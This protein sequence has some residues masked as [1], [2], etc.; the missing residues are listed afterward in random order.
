MEASDGVELLS[1]LGWIGLLWVIS[2]FI[3]GVTKEFDD[4]LTPEVRDSISD[5]LKR[6]SNRDCD[7]MLSFNDVFTK[8]FGPRHLS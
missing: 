3:R 5:W 1:V 2:L 8:V 4:D 6:V 7:W